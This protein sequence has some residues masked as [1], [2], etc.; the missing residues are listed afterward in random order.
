MPESICELAQGCPHLVSELKDQI[1]VLIAELQEIRDNLEQCGCN[2]G[3]S[4]EVKDG[5]L[6]SM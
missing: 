6:E 5:I 3:D 1:D 2:E 4:A